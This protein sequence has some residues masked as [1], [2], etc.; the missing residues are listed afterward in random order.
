MA[1]LK[2][3]LTKASALEFIKKIPDLE[4]RKDGLEL[5]KIFK[6]ATGEK[7]KMW[8]TSII[9]YGMYHYKSERS[10]QEGDWP[11]TGFSPRKQNLTIYLM[12]GFKNYQGLLKDLGKHKTSGGSCLY[13]QKLP[14]VSIKVLTQLIKQSFLEMKKK[15]NS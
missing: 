5:L 8:G 14:D 7:P 4:K 10:S 1:E 11:L 15:Y 9:G 2:T 3:K 6:T 13:I 12:S